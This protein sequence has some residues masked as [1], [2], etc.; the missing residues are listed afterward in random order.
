MII[1]IANQKGGVAKTT[2]ALN[3]GAGLNR[4]GYKTLLIDL[5]SQTDLT[6]GLVIPKTQYTITDV[7]QGRAV[8]KAIIELDNGLSVIP[9]DKR[10]KSVQMSITKYDI[11]TKA[12]RDIKNSYDF[13]I[14]DTSP[15]INVLTINALL[16]SNMILI[17][18]TPEYLALRGLKD[19]KETIELLSKNLDIKPAKIKILITNYDKRKIHH[20]EAAQLI[21]ENFKKELL[22]IR[23]RTNV[24]LADSISQGKSIFEYQPLSHGSKD[25]E[26]LT[27]EIIRGLK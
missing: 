14:I 15:G 11:L 19:F 3:L 21:E 26:A 13:I 8:S 2:T 16:T 25:Y 6:T 7:I 1:S 17:P 20:R 24:A 4:E 10:L 23:I 18:L 5:D 22:N 9:A 12:L 27:K